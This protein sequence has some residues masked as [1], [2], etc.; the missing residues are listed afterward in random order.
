MNRVIV[1]CGPTAS[2]KTAL[3][4][5][6]CE[7]LDGE[8]VSCDSMQIYKELEIGTAKP[9]KEEREMAVHHLVDFV[10][11]SRRY[12][13][14]DYKKDAEKT[15]EDIISRGKTP[16]LVGGTGL[17]INSIIY[18]IN[19]KEEKTDLEYRKELEKKDIEEL[20]DLAKKIDSE[21]I[22]KISKND[23]KRIIR[24]LEIYKTTGKTKTELEKKSREKQK[25]DFK[26]FVLSMDR[27]KLYEKINK[28]VD[29][30]IENGL[31]QEVKNIISKYDTMPT[32]MQGI[33]Y[34]EVVEYLNNEITYDEMVEKIKQ[35]T[36]RYAKR[37][38]T[39]FKSYENAI[40]LDSL[41]DNNID[42]IMEEIGEEKGE[43]K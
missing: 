32:A 40:W 41:N 11:P 21:A 35:E 8:I 19:Y 1:I 6:L 39:W 38:I 5:K 18:N 9:T 13:V 33:G 36:R 34:K 2:G 42:I 17:Y 15:I 14:A 28:R 37:Q 22:E 16:V 30:M 26:V 25:Y 23:K 10:E 27:E 20:Y 43:K 24:I 31:V 29:I 7:K 4:I 12:S 3:G